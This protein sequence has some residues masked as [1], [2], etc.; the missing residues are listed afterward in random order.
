MHAQRTILTI[1]INLLLHAWLAM[2]SGGILANILEVVRNL[3]HLIAL[4]IG[5]NDINIV[6][7]AVVHAAEEHEF[8]KLPQREKHKLALVGPS[9]AHSRRTHHTENDRHHSKPLH[10]AVVIDMGDPGAV[11]GDEAAG[12]DGAGKDV[13]GDEDALVPEEDL[14]ATGDVGVGIGKVLALADTLEPVVV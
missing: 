8:R 7:A 1:V 12:I 5:H 9:R 2:A 14:V 10:G 6:A 11:E 4:E 3:I 13:L